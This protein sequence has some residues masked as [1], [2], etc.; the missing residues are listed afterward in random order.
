M[1]VWCCLIH[2]FTTVFDDQA[3]GQDGRDSVIFLAHAGPSQFDLRER[4]AGATGVGNG[5]A[6]FR[7][8]CIIF[9][10]LQTSIAMGREDYRSGRWPPMRPACR[11]IHW[12][13][14]SATGLGEHPSDHGVMRSSPPDGMNDVCVAAR[15]EAKPTRRHAALGVSGVVNG[16]G[17]IS[18]IVARPTPPFFSARRIVTATPWKRVRRHRPVLG[19][20]RVEAAP[21]MEDQTVKVSSPACL[22]FHHA[23]GPGRRRSLTVLVPCVGDL[24]CASAF[25]RSQI[26]IVH[27]RV[28]AR[29]SQLFPT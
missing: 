6:S 5:A 10:Y 16:C 28:R 25:R 21:G 1:G 19:A 9:A 29:S 26:F 23:E 17:T 22:Q 3:T 20:V 27:S 11:E 15:D 2:G 14:R 24:S 12:C 18:A 7:M 13:Q 4:C 8:V